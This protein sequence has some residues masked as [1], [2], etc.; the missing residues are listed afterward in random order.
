[1]EL[2]AGIRGSLGETSTAPEYW[3]TRLEVSQGCPADRAGLDI[4]TQVGVIADIAR[5]MSPQFGFH[6]FPSPD[7]WIMLTL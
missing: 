7:I 6:N 4:K 5:T 3:S 1:M 2:Y